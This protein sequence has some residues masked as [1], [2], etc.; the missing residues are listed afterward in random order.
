LPDALTSV[1]LEDVRDEFEVFVFE[2]T[3][4]LDRGNSIERS[5]AEVPANMDS[6]DSEQR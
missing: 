3:E 5:S 6:P 4:Q 1:Q 2:G